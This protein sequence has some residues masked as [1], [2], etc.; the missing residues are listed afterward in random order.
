MAE[1]NATFTVRGVETEADVRTIA[2]ELEKLEGVMG[3]QIDRES[4]EAE[5][6]YDVEFLAEERIKITVRD[7]GYDVE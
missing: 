6:R 3:V 4:G 5:I 1:N 2:E 7:M